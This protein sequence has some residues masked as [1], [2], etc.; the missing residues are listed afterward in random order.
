MWVL[1]RERRLVGFKFRRQYP[2]GTFIADFCCR[3]RKLIIELDG[4][5]HSTDPQQAWD[6][7]RDIY[8]HQRGYK[9]LRFRNE[10]VLNNPEAVLQEIFKAFRP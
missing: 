4:D 7:N 9:V 8:L 10:S 5:V 1:L 2:V 3:E 6:E